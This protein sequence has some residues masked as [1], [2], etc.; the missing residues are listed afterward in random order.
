[1]S[2]CKKQLRKSQT[3]KRQFIAITILKEMIHIAVLSTEMLFKALPVQLT[4]TILSLFSSAFKYFAVIVTECLKAFKIKEN[5]VKLI[6]NFHRR[7]NDT[8]TSF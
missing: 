2:R 1:M 6:M 8:C 7:D 5:I 4:F 3:S